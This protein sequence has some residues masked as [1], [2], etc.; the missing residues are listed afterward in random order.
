VIAMRD[1]DREARAVDGRQYDYEFDRIVRDYMMR[2]F[3]PFLPAGPALELGCHLGESTTV[4]AA[5]FPDLTVVDAAA[6]MIAAARAVLPPRVRFVTG[7]FESVDLPGGYDAIFLINA[8]EHVDDAVTVLHRARGW[9]SERGRL[10]V[11]V[12]NANAPSRQIAVKMGLLPFN[13][14]VAE[15]ERA[16]GH[17]RTYAFD[18][19]EADLRSAGLTLVHRGGI[20]FKALANFQMDRALQAG[21]ITPS[22][23]DGCYQLGVQYP[24]LCASI[25]AICVR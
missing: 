18:T 23:I 4:L 22:Y 5:R 16:H 24:D 15:T 10:F 6:T 17:R 1:Y 13:Q 19:L 11:L 8:L 20:I 21:I 3:E 9:L 7:T 14:A 2:A 12:P 25:Y